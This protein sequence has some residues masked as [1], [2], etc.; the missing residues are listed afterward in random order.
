VNDRL[1]VLVCDDEPQILRALRV[2]LREAGFEV[3]PA[4]SRREALDS[5]AVQPP[6]AAI[7]DLVL[8][9]GDGVDVCRALR[10][11]SELPIVVLSAV[12]DEAE[13]VR[14]L[15]AGADD[16]VTKPFGPS[17]LIA[18]LNAALRRAAPR[19][20]AAPVLA[21]DGL[22]LDLMAH[23]VRRDGQPVHLTPIEFDLLRMLMRN[24]GRLMTHRALLT[25]VWGPAYASDTQTLRVHVANLRRKIEPD[26][27]APRYITTD[28][29]VGYRFT[30]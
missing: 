5:A 21:A 27:G 11:W 14:A 8:P 10:E 9:D 30:A 23:E 15:N 26:P 13:K 20:D 7:V 6:D 17:E 2:I 3:L 4:S 28:P 25:E 16:Y 24:R 22:E 19:D 1:R 29:G 12:G 18:R